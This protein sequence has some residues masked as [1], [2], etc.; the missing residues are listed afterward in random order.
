MTKFA[1][2]FYNPS[3]MGGV[4][5]DIVIG[6]ILV[7]SMLWSFLEEGDC[8]QYWS[9]IEPVLVT[10]SKQYW[11]PREVVLVGRVT[12][13]GRKAPWIWALRR[14]L[15]E[16]ILLYGIAY[17][18]QRP[19]CGRTAFLDAMKTPPLRSLWVEDGGVKWEGFHKFHRE[20]ELLS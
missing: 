9:A 12:S 17:K 15:Y 8:D 4:V 5:P 11:S 20:S 7:Y 1:R 10:N 18:D 2:L 19:C 13:T 14:Q 3:K 16:Y 6:I